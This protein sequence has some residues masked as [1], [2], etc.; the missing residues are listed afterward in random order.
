MDTPTSVAGKTWKL[1]LDLEK[2]VI[3]L[4]K[5]FGRQM[6]QSMWAKQ[7]RTAKEKQQPTQLKQN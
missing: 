4:K 5:K 2:L 3:L 6:K 1:H 7:K